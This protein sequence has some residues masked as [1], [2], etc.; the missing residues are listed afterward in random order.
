L[1]TLVPK[2]WEPVMRHMIA[3]SAQP[4][5][6][7]MPGSRLIAPSATLAKVTAM[8]S[9]HGTEVGVAALRH[10]QPSRAR[11]MLTIGPTMEMTKLVVEALSR[12]LYTW[13]TKR[14]QPQQYLS[15]IA[16]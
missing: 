1:A 6:S 12:G 13:G 7:G 10:H 3:C 15:S 11:T 8:S 5:P 14:V 4:P 16:E 9:S 2:Y